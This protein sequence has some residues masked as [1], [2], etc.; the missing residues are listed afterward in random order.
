MK[1][2]DISLV[3]NILIVV[4]ELIGFI[5][6]FKIFNKISI[7]FYTQD[8]NILAL[9]SSLIY[10]IYLLL[11]KKIPKWLKEFKYITTVSLALTFFVV[12]L[13][14][15]PMFNYAYGY[16]LF[17]DIML[18][19][20][21]LCPILGIITFIFFDDINKY[22]KKDSLIA[23]SFTIIYAVVLIILNL[24]NVIE[25]PYPFLRVRY[26]SVFASIMWL[27]LIPGLSYL[28]SYEL[29]KLNY[30]YNKK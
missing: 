26:Q 16:L 17:H 24:V 27:I 13:I 9:F 6:S 5:L 1:K 15:A 25:G 3:L 22:D 21:L 7:E 18:Y 10:V 14:L 30:R 29:R 12:I 23:I 19:E 4:L 8:S 11:N 20:H 2:K 28:L